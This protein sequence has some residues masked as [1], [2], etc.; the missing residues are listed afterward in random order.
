MAVKAKQ[1]PSYNF[2]NLRALGYFHVLQSVAT[3][4][5]AMTVQLLALFLSRLSTIQPKR[6]DTDCQSC[7]GV[8]AA[9]E[10]D[11]VSSI[12]LY[13]GKIH[14]RTYER[15]CGKRVRV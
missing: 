10:E 7:Q 3:Y 4:S 14:L 8:L 12:E 13:W 5:T 15:T 2:S 11:A 6:E 1:L 9:R